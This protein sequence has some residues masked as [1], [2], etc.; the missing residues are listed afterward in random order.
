MGE[1]K[2]LKVKGGS[3][4]SVA[5]SSGQLTASHASG[6]AV[7]TGNSVIS[8]VDLKTN[9]V[10]QC[11][12]SGNVTRFVQCFEDETDPSHDTVTSL[13]NLRSTDDGRT[14]LDWAA[15]LGNTTMVAELVS[16]GADINSVSEKGYSVLHLSAAW[17]QIDCLKVL[18]D[19]GADLQLRNALDERPRDV[20]ARYRIY[21]CIEY[22]DW[23]D[24]RHALRVLITSV[25]EQFLTPDKIKALSKDDKQTVTNLVSQQSDWLD[26][27]TTDVSASQI[28]EQ[29]QFVEDTVAPITAKLTELAESRT[30]KSKVEAT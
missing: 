14:P 24:A 11:A 17:G 12:M 19:N 28:N 3:K 29:K 18:V 30:E 15:M 16:R 20:A 6:S 26:K 13:I 23:A 21:P 5:A 10:L 8:N 2:H 1:N 4:L 9:I 7:S 27:L 22:L 25:K